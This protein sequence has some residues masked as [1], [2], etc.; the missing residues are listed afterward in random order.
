M[1]SKNKSFLSLV[2]LTLVC[3]RFSQANLNQVGT[4]TN[5][6]NYNSCTDCRNSTC[7]L[8]GYTDQ[9]CFLKWSYAVEDNAVDFYLKIK[10]PSKPYWIRLGFNPSKKTVSQVFQFFRPNLH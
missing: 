8:T 9:E 3:S 7:L 5:S 10:T 1:K 4:A 6:Y 2:W